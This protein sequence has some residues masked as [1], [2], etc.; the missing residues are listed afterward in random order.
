[1]E[2]EKDHASFVF[3]LLRNPSTR[4]EN[5]RICMKSS[6]LELG[7]RKKQRVL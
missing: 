6:V 3:S 2:K 5:I 7:Y 1:M 4:K